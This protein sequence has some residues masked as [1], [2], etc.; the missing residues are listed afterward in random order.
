MMHEVL[1]RYLKGFP[2]M[3][4]IRE[5]IDVNMTERKIITYSKRYGQLHVVHNG[6]NNFL[7][8]AK[9]H[10]RKMKSQPS[11]ALDHMTQIQR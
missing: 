3:I 1:P 8:Y 4:K 6:K 9:I 10:V 2:V 5:R 7:I 11:R